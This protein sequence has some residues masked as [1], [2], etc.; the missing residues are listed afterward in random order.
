MKVLLIGA[1]GVGEAI[2]IIAQ[3]KPWLKKMVLAE[4]NGARFK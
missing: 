4:Y 1:G 2:A 3:D